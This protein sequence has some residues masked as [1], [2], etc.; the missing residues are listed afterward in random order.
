MFAF[1]EQCSRARS[2]AQLIQIQSSLWSTW[3]I[4][5]LLAHESH[6]WIHGWHKTT[7][8]TGR[9]EQLIEDGNHVCGYVIRERTKASHWM[10]SKVC[11]C[12][13]YRCSQ[14]RSQASHWRIQQCINFV[15]KVHQYLNDKIVKGL[16]PCN[17]SSSECQPNEERLSKRHHKCNKFDITIFLPITV[18]SHISAIWPDF[19]RQHACDRHDV[20]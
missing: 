2:H 10:R 17:L 9:I 13:M 20:W 5:F 16:S 8:V 12:D 14:A 7:P 18:P 1:S 19:F 3:N 11:I 4:D 6:N 15:F